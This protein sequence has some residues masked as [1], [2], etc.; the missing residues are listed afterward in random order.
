MKGI[1]NKFRKQAQHLIITKQFLERKSVLVFFFKDKIFIYSYALP[2]NPLKTDQGLT[3]IFL[4]KN[5]NPQQIGEKKKKE[6]RLLPTK[7]D[8]NRQ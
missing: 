6:F 2:I 5:G 7:I 8:K 4:I 3:R 1:S